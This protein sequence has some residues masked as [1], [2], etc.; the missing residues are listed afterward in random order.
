MLKEIEEAF[1]MATSVVLGKRLAGLEGYEGWLTTQVR[2]PLLRHSAI[3]GKPFQMAPFIRFVLTQDK[4]VDLDESYGIAG[5][6]SLDRQTAR[7]LTMAN[8]AA[9]LG[10]MVYYSPEVAIG[11]NFEMDQCSLIAN[12]SFCFRTFYVAEC[13]FCAYCAWPRESEYVFGSDQC[14]SSKFCFKC[15]NS[16]NLTR[17]L[18]VSNSA[19]SSD[20]YF[21]HNVEN[22]AECMF[23]FNVKAK[24]YAIGNVEMKKEDYLRIK[25]M[26]LDEIGARLEKNKKLGISI[27]NIGSGESH[28]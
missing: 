5:K 2:I 8:A 13:K 26:V 1:G 27:Y 6:K 18:E 19:N 28:E 24:R 15:Y 25:K 12:S 16:V 14:F 7:S 21:C 3:S 4:I 20:L 17:C 23:C 10:G 9:A 22:C 11:K